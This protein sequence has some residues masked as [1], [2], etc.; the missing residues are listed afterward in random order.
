MDVKTLTDEL[1]SVA[2]LVVG[3]AAGAFTTFL[4]RKKT[5]AEAESTLSSAILSYTNK[6]T[7]DMDNLRAH[8]NAAD[9]H[10]AKLEDEI[11]TIRR[12]LSEAEIA[13]VQLQ[14]IVKSLEARKANDKILI[15]QLVTALKAVDPNNPII[16]KLINS[17]D[18][19]Y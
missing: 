16:T 12:K 17:A 5:A 7:A 4:T 14:E 13:R 6:L 15:D 3:L 8:L 11:D 1:P 19:P 2:F 9:G 10:K 18:V